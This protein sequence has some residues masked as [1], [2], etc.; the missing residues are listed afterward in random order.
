MLTR[1]GY[2]VRWILV[3]NDLAMRPLR[4]ISE[5]GMRKTEA[6]KITY[7]QFIQDPV[8]PFRGE[9]FQE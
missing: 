6:W 2:R 3:L 8:R 4:K 7:S 9:F 1:T 5:R